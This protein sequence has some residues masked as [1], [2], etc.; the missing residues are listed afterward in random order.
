MKANPCIAISGPVPAGR[1]GAT[2]NQSTVT[3]SQNSTRPTYFLAN[4]SF[5][6]HLFLPTN[7][8]QQ[9]ILPS[10]PRSSTSRVNSQDGYVTNNFLNKPL[11]AS[12]QFVQA[13]N[14]CETSGAARLRRSF[15]TERDTGGTGIERRRKKDGR[16]TSLRTFS[17]AANSF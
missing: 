4:F 8:Q 10:T 13:K 16:K 1:S 15:F 11:Y 3:H 7:R 6:L 12:G 9:S 14:V 2:A 5:C 17:S